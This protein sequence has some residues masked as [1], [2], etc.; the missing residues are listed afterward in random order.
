[1]K[2]TLILLFI[3]LATFIGNTARFEDVVIPSKLMKKTFSARVILPDNYDGKK[4]FKQL[5]L[6]HGASG[7]H[8]NWQERVKECDSYADKY[9]RIIICPTAGKYSWYNNY[10]K[11]EDYIIQEVVPFIDK[12]YNT[13]PDRWLT[14]LSMGGYGAIRLGFKY[15]KLFSAYGGQ[16]PCIKP[17]KWAK[18]WS[19]GKKFK[20][21]KDDHFRKNMVTKLKTET[22]PFTILCGKQ[23][24]FF[25][26]NKQALELCNKHK[27]DVY[28]EE[29]DGAHN[30]DY[31]SQSLPKQLS[32][33]ASKTKKRNEK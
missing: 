29:M 27:I 15:P 14:G 13:T 1:M 32:F 18:K 2:K 31:W 7:D 17:S 22:R 25:K 24:F 21:G 3:T 28:Y 26:E 5:Y 23:D 9:Q 16:S 20:S 10:N 33:F 12:K 30:W 19:I 8:T 6:L 4:P 11:S